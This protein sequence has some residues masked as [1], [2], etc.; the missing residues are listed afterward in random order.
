MEHNPYAPFKLPQ[1]V[2]ESPLFTKL[3]SNDVVA[4]I[5]V[6]MIFQHHSTAWKLAATCRE[7]SNLMSFYIV[8]QPFR[9]NLHSR[10]LTAASESLG[11]GWHF[12]GWWVVQQ[13]RAT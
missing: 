7:A 3:L 4:Q 12:Q 9:Q 10:L 8:R 13:L 2:Q 6:P 11:Y 5:V 1:A